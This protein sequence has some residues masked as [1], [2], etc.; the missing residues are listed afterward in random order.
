MKPRKEYTEENRVSESLI[1]SVSVT[2]EII[3]K[4]KREGYEIRE[5]TPDELRNDPTSLMH[6]H[7]GTLKHDRYRPTK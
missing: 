1:A 5:K 3:N 7:K 4:V 2:P 6:I